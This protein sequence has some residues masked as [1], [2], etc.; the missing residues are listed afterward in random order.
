MNRFSLLALT[1]A[2]TMLFSSVAEAQVPQVIS[3][4][5]RVAV[6][7]VNFDSATAGHAG[8]FKFALVSPDG[9]ATYWSNDGTS[10]AGSAPTAA[11]ALTVTKG[12]YSVLLGDTGAPLSMSAI[13]AGVF[14]HP[15]VRLRVW[16]DDGAH[17]S[18]LLA[19]DRRIASVAYAV[20]AGEVADGS[21][22]SAKIAA[23]AVGSAQLAVNAVQTANLAAGA[24]DNT[25]LENVAVTVTAGAGLGGGG[26]VSLGGGVTLNNTGV[27]SLAGGGGITVSGVNGNVTLGSNATGLNTGGTI[28]KR[29]ANG[30]FA[31]G[32]ITGN[33][34]GNALTAVSAV[35]ATSALT[36]LTAGSAVDFTGVLAGDV[37]GAQ[38]AT[39]V[40][41]IGGIVPASAN[42]PGAVVKRDA[43]GNFAAGTPTFASQTI[44]NPGAGLNKP[45]VVLD[46]GIPPK[47]ANDGTG[48]KGRLTFQKSALDPAWSGLVLSVNA[49]WSDLNGYTYDDPNRSQSF[50]QMEYEW[51]ELGFPVNELNWTTN[52]RRLWYSWGRADDYTKA[53]VQWFAPTKI[54]V[55]PYEST[56]EPALFVEDTKGGLVAGSG[57]RTQMII[58]NSNPN[59]GT[60]RGVAFRMVGIVPSNN[61][62]AGTDWYVGIDSAT[63][64]SNN[65]FIYDSIQ[66]ANRLFIDGSG[67]VGLGGNTAPAAK[68]DVT[69]GV[70]VTGTVNATGYTLNGVPLQTLKHSLAYGGG[71]VHAMGNAAGSGEIWREA[72]SLNNAFSPFGG[73]DVPGLAGRDQGP[74]VLQAKGEHSRGCITLPPAWANGIQ[75]KVRTW[76]CFKPG[77]MAGT[78][79]NNSVVL[80]QGLRGR[81]TVPVSVS[82]SV[83]AGWDLPAAGSGEQ[84]KTFAGGIDGEILMDERIYTIPA[85]SD[86]NSRQVIFGRAGSDAADLET[87]D[88]YFLGVTIEEL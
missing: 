11:V 1:L 74:F 19:P 51:S 73:G 33:L 59:P 32:T 28:V 54:I 63:N 87:A 10:V 62:P 44:L 72:V 36:A 84:T 56:G 8:L 42:T 80:N 21:I 14:A 47:I 77:D 83:G 4:E 88:I 71:Q 12:L 70:N 38:G 46:R 43:N 26:V 24:V 53:S 39:V 52:G 67:N 81:S 27:L 60:S 64:G 58:Q 23:G 78:A 13:T 18:Q 65:F 17:G 79:P 20:L 61:A 7:G 16:F 25:K 45:S 85:G 69:G 66:Q 86:R 40:G 76:Y 31:A 55:P 2:G 22:S 6:G 35:N 49:D 82:Q 15:D 30:D 9:T 29:D 37:T 50:L 57:E 48:P 34:A 75:V 3:Y 41:K 68:L 5:G